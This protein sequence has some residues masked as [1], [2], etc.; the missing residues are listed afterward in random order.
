MQFELELALNSTAAIAAA[1]YPLLR[2]MKVATLTEYTKADKP[3]SNVTLMIDWSMSSPESVPGL[4]GVCFFAGRDLHLSQPAA[5]RRPLGLID[6]CL[7]GSYIE[8]W[9]TGR[10]LARCPGANNTQTFPPAETSALWYSKIWPLLPLSIRAVLWDQGESN[11][12]LPDL[13]KCELPVML[14]DWR[15]WWS[16]TA[17]PKGPASPLDSFPFVYRQLHAY[18]RGSL[19]GAMRLAMA[20]AE[21]AVPGMAYYTSFDIGNMTSPWG[22]IHFPDKQEAGRRAALAM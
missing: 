7:G 19:H 20:E 17:R 15:E 3:Q 1:S 14:T 2:V 10:A 18:P 13:Y 21:D 8:S 6:S 9:M 12:D 22:N 11:I 5:T 16:S 4:S